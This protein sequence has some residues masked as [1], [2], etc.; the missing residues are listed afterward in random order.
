MG[1][2]WGE[3]KTYCLWGR[4]SGGGGRKEMFKA[5]S[6]LKPKEKINTEGESHVGVALGEGKNFNT[7]GD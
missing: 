1:S 5:T 6:G 4:S 7:G 2:C 3:K